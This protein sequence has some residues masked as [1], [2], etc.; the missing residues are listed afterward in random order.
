MKCCEK[1]NFEIIKKYDPKPQNPDGSISWYLYRWDD[2]KDGYRKLV[3]C[4]SCGAYFLVQCYRLNKF[5]GKSSEIYED[6]YKVK[7]EMQADSMNRQYT[8]LQLELKY[9][10]LKS[11]LD[12]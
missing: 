4:K 8:G 7:N 1:P 12:M 11:E 3:R 2:G 5:T 9:K 6:W 10:K